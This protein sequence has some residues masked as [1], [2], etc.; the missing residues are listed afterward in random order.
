MIDFVFLVSTALLP[1]RVSFS[2]ATVK[3]IASDKIQ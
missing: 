1:I 2:Q 3:E